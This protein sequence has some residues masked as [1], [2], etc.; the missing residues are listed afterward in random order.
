[1]SLLIYG[2]A[3]W[4]LALLTTAHKTLTSESNML[5]TI[6]KPLPAF[7]G[8][9]YV[10]LFQPE[11]T[12]FYLLLAV[13]LIFC[14]L[15]DIAME[16]NILPGLGL[17]LFAHLFFVIN[18]LQQSIQQGFQLIPFAVFVVC[19]VGLLFYIFFYHRYLKTSEKGMDHKMLR[20]VDIY[21]LA[22]SLTLSTSLL[23]WLSTNTFL[24]FLLVVGAVFFIISDSLIGIREFHHEFKF[25]EPAIL[26]TYYMAIFLLSMGVVAYIFWL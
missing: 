7:I 15:G 14:G 3:F 24:G 20:A 16:Y 21:A 19:L 10:L 11:F 12:I 13:A 23:L 8:A 18:F 6:V 17:F 5:R 1:M 26:L 25:Q 9:I 4:A 22:I 2:I